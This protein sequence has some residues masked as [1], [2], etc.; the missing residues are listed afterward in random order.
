ATSAAGLQKTRRILRHAVQAY[1]EMQMRAGR[2]SG[3]ADLRD[4]LAPYDEVAF[5]DQQSRTMRVP[6]DQSVAMIDF[7]HF[8]IG[9][10]HVREHDLAARGGFDRGADVGRKIDAFVET[11]LSG[12]RIEAPA[13]I[14]RIPCILDRL[15]RGQ[16]LL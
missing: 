5:A 13:E 2:A 3:R 15:Q 10:M 8:T 7:D 16:K 11:L 6:A 12:E 4:Q 9:R 1:L 14:G